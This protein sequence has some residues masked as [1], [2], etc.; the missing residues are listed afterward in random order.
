MNAAVHI[1][2]HEVVRRRLPSRRQPESSWHVTEVMSAPAGARNG[3]LVDVVRW[4]DPAVGVGGVRAAARC[5]PDACGGRVLQSR[6][7]EHDVVTHRARQ[8]S[9]S[10]LRTLR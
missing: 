7:G 8:C 5:S 4:E 10:I 3:E 1:G 9:A 2:H 6:W